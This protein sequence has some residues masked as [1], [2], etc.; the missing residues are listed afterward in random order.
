MLTR[1]AS[2]NTGLV[3][4]QLA[5]L[6][7]LRVIVVADAARHGSKLYG[8]GPDILVDRHDPY[9]AIQII[10]NVTNG[11]LRFGLD[12]VGKDTATHLQEALQQSQGNRQGHLIGL[13]GLPKTK[14]PS[15]KYHAVP[16]KIFH[17]VPV[18][19]EHTMDWLESLLVEGAVQPPE[20][21]TVEGG[22]EGINGALDKLRSGA[23]SGKRLVVPIEG[24][25]TSD[26]SSNR[27]ANGLIGTKYPKDTL[28]YADKLN[29]DPSRIKFA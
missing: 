15:I 22:L 5:K 2:S 25:K 27:T 20:V 29:S 8:L 6:A 28:E 17:E 16:I 24:N 7:G 4:L 18:I 23:V 1:I 10:R 13:T 14:L 11:N 26:S 12:T 9:R 19:G 3:A 21:A